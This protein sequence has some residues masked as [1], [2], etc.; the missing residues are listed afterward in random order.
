MKF[1]ELT[2]D[3]KGAIFDLDGTLVDSMNVWA[4]I[5]VEFFKDRGI[6]EVPADFA[7]NIAHMN[8]VDMAKYTIKRFGFS[9][10]PDEIIKIWLDKSIEAYSHTVRAKPG[11]KELLQEMKD[12]GIKISLATSNKRELFEP[13]LKNNDLYQYFDHFLNV[14]EINSSK[15]EPTIYL[16]LADKMHTKP[17]QT[18]VF[19]DIVVALN[20]AADAG[21]KT[22]A[23]YDDSS[24]DAD[25][26]KRKI[27][28]Y[29]LKDFSE[30]NY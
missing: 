4:D 2:A 7:D 23:I 27:S 8:F 9:D 5:D 24:K 22:V 15:S 18:L 17:S 30:I 21:F 12:H 6:Y 19:E 29:Y 26:L 1:T 10:T 14:N 25:G 16:N 11:A 3:I 13:C 28:Y 20:T